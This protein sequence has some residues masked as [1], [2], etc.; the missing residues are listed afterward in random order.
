M[1]VSVGLGVVLIGMVVLFFAGRAGFLVVLRLGGFVLV[2]C[3]L[4]LFM[5]LIGFTVVTTTGAGFIELGCFGLLV[6]LRGGVLLTGLRG[7]GRGAE[8]HLP[9]TT[10]SFTSRTSFAMVG[11]LTQTW[12]SPTGCQL[13]DQQS[14]SA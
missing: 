14:C 6:V 10:L 5:S 9:D 4:V 1:V 2:V 3:V 8:E 7:G 12:L 11:C 13:Q